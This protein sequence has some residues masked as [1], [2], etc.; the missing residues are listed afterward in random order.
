MDAVNNRAVVALSLAGAGGYQ[1]L[2]L[3]TSTFEPAFL[4]KAPTALFPS[5]SEEILIDPIRNLVLSASENNNY[6]IVNVATSTSPTFFEN[7]ISGLG[8]TQLDSAGEDCSTGIALAP[9]EFAEPSVVYIADLTQGTFTAG[10]PGT[11]TAPSQNQ[12][13]T[14]SDLDAGSSGIA[15]AQGTHT[16]ILTGEFFLGGEITAIKLPSTSGS[17]TPAIQD[18]VTCAISGFSVGFDPHTLT[19]YQTPNGG[20]AIAVLSNAGATTLA[21]VDLTQMLNPTIVPRT[22]GGHAC[23]STTLPAGVVSFIP[24]P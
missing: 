18:W 11:W 6:E 16:G 22:V 8:G 24:V 19:A 17:G 5:I 1:V 21:K 15:I 23:A 13:L 9:A 12:T 2:N 14:E 7:A 4:S 20:D 3:G 10:N